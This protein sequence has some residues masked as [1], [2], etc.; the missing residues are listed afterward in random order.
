MSALRL[1]GYTAGR[2]LPLRAR[3]TL[4]RRSCLVFVFSE[5][6]LHC[7]T[8]RGRLSTIFQST[9]P[10]R[11][12][13]EELTPEALTLISEHQCRALGTDGEHIA[14]LV[15]KHLAH[16]AKEALLLRLGHQVQRGAGKAAAM[17]AVRAAIMQHILGHG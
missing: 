10:M 9:P 3:L 15:A 4:P 1:A 11:G 7:S 14:A 6:Q 5:N 16:V 17:H 8:G 2:E 13:T 12:A